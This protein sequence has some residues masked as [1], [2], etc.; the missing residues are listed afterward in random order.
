MDLLWFFWEISLAEVKIDYFTQKLRPKE[1]FHFWGLE[2]GGWGMKKNGSAGCIWMSKKKDAFS[3][4]FSQFT[5]KGND[6]GTR[7]L[8]ILPNL[9]ELKLEIQKPLGNINL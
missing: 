5:A 2:A 8:L 9:A 3:W 7:T 6:F 4:Q 1:H